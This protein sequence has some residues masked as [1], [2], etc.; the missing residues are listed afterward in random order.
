[1]ELFANGQ[2]NNVD[3]TSLKANG[4]CCW[5]RTKA[6]FFSFGLAI[7]LTSAQSLLASQPLPPSL[8]TAAAQIRAMSVEEAKQKHP[9]KLRGVITYYDPEEPD[10]FIQ[11][12]TG[13]VWV[14]L[15]IVKP[16][17][18][19]KAG[20][21]V[22]V[23]GVTEAPDFAPQIGNPVFKVIGRAPLPPARR[24]SFARMASTQEDSQRVETEG[25]VHKVFKKGNRLYLEV[26]IA[27]GQVIGRLP[28]YTRDSL[29]QLVD[30]RVRLRGTCGAQFNSDNQLTGVYINIPYES[31]I[32]VLQSPPADPFNIPTR[33]ISDLLRFNLSGDLGHR[34][35]VHG[36]VTLYRPGKAIFVQNDSG[37]IFA[38]TQES[39]S[40]IAS[41]DQVDLIG[42]PVVGPYQPELQNASVR[43]TGPGDMPKPLTLSA[44]EA[45]HGDFKG[46]NLFH[47]Y[48]ADLIS[49][50]GR[51]T[52]YSLNP[53]EQILH[54]QDGSTV[55]EAELSSA[56]VPQQF[57]SLRESTQLQVSGI[58]TIEVD[59]NRQPVRFRLRLRSF[60]DVVIVSLP[61]WWNLR[62]TLALIGGMVLA[63]LIVLTWAATLR[64]RVREATKALQ[65]AK[66]AA[67]TANDAKSTF[68]AT[69]SHEIRT[70]MNGIL[71]MTELVLDTDLTAEQRD[72]LG[73]VKFS[74]E[75]LLT[76]INDILDFSKIEARK[77]DLESIPFDL[78][79]SLGETMDTLGYRAHQKGLELMCDVQPDLPEAFLGDPGRLRQIIVNLVGNS[80]KFTERGEI[81]VSVEAGKKT[82]QAME[83]KF[84]IKDTGVGI[85]PAQ[86]Q[87]IFEAFSQADGS[88]ARKYGGTGLGLAICTKLVA[89]MGGRI[90]V[91]SA[92]GAG[93]TFY[94]TAILQPH[95]PDERLPR[96]APRQLEELRGLHVLIVDDNFT[97]RR[98]LTGMLARWGMNSTAV[99]DG[100]AALLALERA[101]IEGRAFP[102]ILLDGQM[103]EMDGFT[104]AEQ[105]QKQPNL[106]HATVMM[107][108]SAGHLGDAA[109]CRALGIAAY[110]VKPIRQ[111]EL[112]DAICQ[113]LTQ[114]PQTRGVPLVTR[115]TL[116]EDKLSFR[117]L[118]AEDNPV[119]QTLAVRLLQKRG[120]SVTV[121]ADGRAAVEA[122]EKEQF[123]LVLMDIQMPGMDGFEA[124]ASIRE[125]EK[126]TGRRIPI[127]AMTAHALKGD[128]ERCI[129]AGMDGYVSKPIRTTELFSMLDSL[130]VG[131]PPV[132]A[133]V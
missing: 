123:D 46:E 87:K 74:A 67:E 56:Q 38:H 92:T 60:Q 90:W 84:A 15:E 126:V 44:S 78:R 2:T 72:S 54:L 109:R 36:V 65:G 124:T 29:P 23:Q 93:S 102:L 7:L 28:F 39:T 13:G 130:L 59:E 125:K 64:R 53:G 104:L 118:L 70:P 4:R 100:R 24:V 35:K 61:S 62:R 107:L 76:V 31:E 9:A 79:E 112:L 19:I 51:L 83:L 3:S 32:Q 80:I 16:N 8:V 127:V 103:P 52:G 10:L 108:T 25:V 55:F 49:V 101:E 40:D 133:P 111:R 50:Q 5:F 66:E 81:I 115:H 89:L 91:E 117:I 21:V 27:D 11:D 131:K 94:F 95:T 12:S 37:S 99:E 20:D 129:A 63:M 1:L 71:G 114:G 26:T 30:A 96:V 6:I 82:A 105:I 122:F 120:H 45:L 22:E 18:P 42:F 86:Q 43:R 116:R 128:Q 58:C 48:D 121:A 57:R 77:L 110:L 132:N 14:N 106:V 68:L 75:S 33:A 119:N 88:M 113:I 47:S 69:M 73:L 17:V 98:V 34:V 97:N 41:G 85:P